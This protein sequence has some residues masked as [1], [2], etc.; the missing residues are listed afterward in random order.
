MESMEEVLEAEEVITGVFQLEQ[1]RTYSGDSGNDS[2]SQTRHLEEPGQTKGNT[3]V[4]KDSIMPEVKEEN[5]IE[6]VQVHIKTE[7]EATMLSALECTDKTF[8]DARTC[9]QQTINP[10]NDQTT[11]IAIKEE[12]DPQYENS[13]RFFIIILLLTML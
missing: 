3:P 7:P 6:V 5:N 2:D 11:A 9:Q 10:G 13:V 8:E 4:M 12:T 1:G